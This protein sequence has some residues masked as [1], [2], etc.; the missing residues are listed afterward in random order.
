VLFYQKAALMA[1]WKVRNQLKLY[2]GFDYSQDGV[3]LVVGAKIAGFKLLL[4]WSGLHNRVPIMDPEDQSNIFVWPCIVACSFLALAYGTSKYCQRQKQ[5][6]VK[7]FLKDELPQ[8]VSKKLIVV[9]NILD[10]A[11]QNQAKSNLKIHVA[12]YGHKAN[13]KKLIAGQNDLTAV[14]L[15]TS[16]NQF[17]LDV[18]IPMRYQLTESGLKIRGGKKSD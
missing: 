3:G 10:K 11:K 15:R 9:R 5:A 12:L 2:G 7:S 6:K 8:L 1:K 17:I 18:T 14:D 13:I 4:P 16:A